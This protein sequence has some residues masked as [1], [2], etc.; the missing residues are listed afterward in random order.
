[1]AIDQQADLAAQFKGKVKQA[2]GQFS[3]AEL[4]SRD[5]AAVETF[6]R[7]YLALLQTCKVAVDFF[8]GVL[9]VR[10][11]LYCSRHQHN[12]FHR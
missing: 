4:I 12:G 10:C 1:M 8:D 7:L 9:S 5:A 6:Y 11:R 3:R 2:G